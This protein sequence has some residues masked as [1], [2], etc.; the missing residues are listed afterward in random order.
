M[1]LCVDQRNKLNLQGS[2]LEAVL[3]SLLVQLRRMSQSERSTLSSVGTRLSSYSEA[4]ALALQVRFFLLQ[5]V[6]SSPLM[7]CYSVAH[8]RSDHCLHKLLLLSTVME[9]CI[10]S[11]A[12]TLLWKRALC[13][14]F[15]CR[16]CLVCSTFRAKAKFF[17]RRVC[18]EA[19]N[20]VLSAFH[21]VCKPKEEHGSS[22]V[23]RTRTSQ[24]YR[25]QA[26]HLQA[27][28]DTFCRQAVNFEVPKSAYS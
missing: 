4:K 10:C 22:N 28:T 21:P 26:F 25:L 14:I 1:Y 27:A 20:D 23:R 9:G 8:S 15:Q 2:W 17:F 18:V 6:L 5:V 7:R 16:V 24:Q 19:A 12:S 3:D 11:V 13:C